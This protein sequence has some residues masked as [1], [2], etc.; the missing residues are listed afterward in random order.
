VNK[1]QREPYYTLTKIQMPDGDTPCLCAFCRFVEQSG[2]CKEPDLECTHPL[3]VVYI[4][5]SE[6]VMVENVDCW[7]F[8][9]Q[10]SIDTAQR[11]VENWL[12]GE[13][14]IIPEELL[15]GRKKGVIT[16]DS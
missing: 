2:D 8:R 9:P 16:H 11:M 5:L 10:I 1:E 14:V 6:D 13:D 12:H 7:A 4:F 3:S 15:L